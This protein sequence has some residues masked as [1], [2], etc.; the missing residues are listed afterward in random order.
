[1]VEE[2]VSARFGVSMVWKN[3]RQVDLVQCL[4]WYNVI[5]GFIHESCIN[6]DSNDTN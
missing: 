2:G 6:L 3:T 5:T 1:M 4:N